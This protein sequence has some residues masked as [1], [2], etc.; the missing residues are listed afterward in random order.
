MNLI[1]NHCAGFPSHQ[2]TKRSRGR[3]VASS[4]SSLYAI[5]FSTIAQISAAIH[6]RTVQPNR[7]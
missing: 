7:S 2:A 1:G 5:G 3:P 4:K 6:P